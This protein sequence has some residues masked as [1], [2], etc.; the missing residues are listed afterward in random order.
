M[1]AVLV[2]A[3]PAA[4]DAEFLGQRYSFMALGAGVGRQGAGGRGSGLIKR[5]LDVVNA[6]T[7]RANRSAGNSSSERHSVNAPIEL[8]G[9]GL[10]ALTAGLGNV[11]FED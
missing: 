10:M 6:M 9:F 1:I 4:R 2:A 5:H 3:H 7:I 8:I 11:N